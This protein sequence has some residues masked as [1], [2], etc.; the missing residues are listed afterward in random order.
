M[1]SS[2]FINM[3]QSPSWV[4]SEGVRRASQQHLTRATR[5]NS[6]P[7]LY[8]EPPS[9]C[10]S[11]STLHSIQGGNH[12]PFFFLWTPSPERIGVSARI[13]DHEQQ[14]SLTDGPVGTKYVK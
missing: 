11:F 7:D 1:L 12:A 2:T 9:R 3:R 6:L 5:I 8:V 4:A 10:C 13:L 14:W